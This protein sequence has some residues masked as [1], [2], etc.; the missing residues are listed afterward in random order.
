[1]KENVLRKTHRN[2][3]ITLA[4][5]LLLQGGSGLLLSASELFEPSVRTVVPA[6]HGHNGEENTPPADTGPQ[7][8]DAKTEEARHG[9]LGRLHHGQGTLWN[10]YRL[11]VGS[12]LVVMLASGTAIYLI[13]RARQKQTNRQS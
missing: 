3:G 4:F 2:L 7:G 10:L 12:G 13:S 9:L 5:F 8:P 1:M 11:A 6:A